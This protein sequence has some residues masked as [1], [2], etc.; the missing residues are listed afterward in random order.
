MHYTLQ[1]LIEGDEEIVTYYQKAKSIWNE[2][3]GIIDCNNSENIPKLANELS[4]RQIIDFEYDCGGKD[5]GQEIMA[6]YGIGQ[7]YKVEDGFGNDYERLQSAKNVY[8]A[9]QK[10]YCSLEVKGYARDVANSYSLEEY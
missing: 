10:S 2:I 9:F 1:K 7:F 6:W 8:E 3:T 4:S 5:I